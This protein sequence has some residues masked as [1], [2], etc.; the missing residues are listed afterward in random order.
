MSF[1]RKFARKDISHI[2][3]TEKLYGNRNERRNRSCIKSR[4]QKSN[5]KVTPNTLQ[6]MSLN[7]S[8]F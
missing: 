2:A 6:G 4:I 1:K 8:P 3:T 7:N 5:L